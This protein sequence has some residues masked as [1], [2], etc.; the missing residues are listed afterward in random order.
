MHVHV[1]PLLVGTAIPGVD[2]SNLCPPIRLLEIVSHWVKTC[3]E[4]LF[5]TQLL[6]RK[7]DLPL[8]RSKKSTALHSVSTSP[9]PGLI[10]WCV[11]APLVDVP[12]HK[13]NKKSI[14]RR[15]S[16]VLSHSHNLELNSGDSKNEK[17]H[18]GTAA[19]DPE[20]EGT[21]ETLVSELHANLLSVILSHPTSFGQHSLTSDNLAVV[22]AALLGFRQQLQARTRDTGGSGGGGGIGCDDGGGGMSESVERL[23][24]FLQISLSNGMLVLSAGVLLYF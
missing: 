6:E 2:P 14:G 20:T 5:P 10:Q 19:A 16:R 7:T 12:H 17:V 9:L 11:L 23:A 4:F 13:P 22:V 8:L 18:V 15:R 21:T 3:P 24:Q 1:Y